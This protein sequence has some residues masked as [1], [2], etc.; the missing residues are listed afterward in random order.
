MLWILA[1][2]FGIFIIRCLTIGERLGYGSIAILFIG[3]YNGNL[4]SS[5]WALVILAGLSW[6]VYEPKQT[7][8]KP[9][10][11]FIKPGQ[12]QVLE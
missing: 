3:A 10:L 8:K 9:K 5:L 6:L 12:F 1:I 11:K 2:I 7:A 4:S